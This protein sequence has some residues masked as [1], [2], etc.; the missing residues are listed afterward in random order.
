MHERRGVGTI[1]AG[2]GTGGH[3][4]PALAL[5]DALVRLRDDVRPFFVG[6]ERGI[7]A[8]VLPTRGVEHLLVPVRGV[9]RGGGLSNW[10]V[11]PDL[12]RSMGRVWKL[13]GRM[14]PEL[15]VVTGGYAGGP[16]GA[17]AV[18][19]GVPL[20]LQ[21]QNSAPGFTT[22]VLSRYARQ[23]HLAYPEAAEHL[24]GSARK[25]VRVTGNPIRPPEPVDIGEA[26]RAFGLDPARP[27]VLVVG[28]SQGSAAVNAVVSEMVTA[29]EVGRLERRAGLQLL[30]ATGP[31]H[32]GTVTRSL[33]DEPPS[34][35]RVVGYIDR[36]ELALGAADLAVSRAGAMATSELLAWGVPMVLIP[37]PTAAANHQELNARALASAGAAVHLEQEGLSGEELWDAVTEL[38]T[39]PV[40]LDAFRQAARGRGRPEAA[41]RIAAAL[42]ELLPGRTVDFAPDGLG[43]G[44][45]S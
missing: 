12:A 27:V 21:E 4:Y 32:L 24:P 5:A 2:G 30:W 14:R 26:R 13:F 29:V 16:A 42:T 6:A 22:R 7:E 25:R 15:V 34:W 18:L 33:G 37:L 39:D 3:L 23:I 35:V 38:A 43:E 36:M 45:G 11:L 19:R 41:H 8:R 9:A 20:A 1:F 44:E 40:R 31:R 28:G 17:V 10:R